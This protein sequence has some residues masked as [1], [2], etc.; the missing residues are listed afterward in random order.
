MKQLHIF[1]EKYDQQ[2]D[3]LGEKNE[4]FD[5]DALV[6]YIVKVIEH[7]E[8]IH[9]VAD[10]NYIANDLLEL[11]QKDHDYLDLI[12]E[13]GAEVKEYSVTVGSGIATPSK[14]T[15]G[16]KVTI[17]ANQAE[18]G[19]V[20]DKW[21]VESGEVVLEDSESTETTFVMGTSDVIVNA[22]Y[23]AIPVY[24]IIEGED[25]SIVAGEAAV[26][27]SNA[28]FSKF[29]EV[30]VDSEIVE[31]DHYDV[32]GCDVGEQTGLTRGYIKRKLYR[33]VRF[34]KSYD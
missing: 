8:D 32:E 24:E 30:R 11:I 13:Q 2:L 18:E 12:T 16:T 19:M 29:K 31:N 25:L 3:Q 22:T 26:F 33:N 20:F 10:K 27:V 17:K 1:D 14:A 21:I 28:E 4:V 7:F 23:K 5:D 9:Q 34:R 6:Y 15:E